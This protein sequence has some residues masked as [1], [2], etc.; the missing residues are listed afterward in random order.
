VSTSVSPS[1]TYSPSSVHYG[2]V[3]GRGVDMMSLLGDPAA[4]RHGV[5][6]ETAGAIDARECRGHVE[7][8]RLLALET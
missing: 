2:T 7:H 8:R 1:A 3:T 5:R 4:E 6:R